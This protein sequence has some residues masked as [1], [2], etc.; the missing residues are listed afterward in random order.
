MAVH[1]LVLRE[2][3]EVMGDFDICPFLSRADDN[4][5]IIDIE[6]ITLECKIWDTESSRCGIMG[7]K[8]MLQQ[9]INRLDDVVIVL[10]KD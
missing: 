10:E 1:V 5:E 8:P 6:C 9:I 2:K 3:E 4:R 7:I